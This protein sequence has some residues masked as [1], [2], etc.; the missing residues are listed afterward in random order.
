MRAASGAGRL[1]AVG[2][3][4]VAATALVALSAASGAAAAGGAAGGAVA[5]Q[6]RCG[7]F[8]NPTPGNVWLLDRDREWIIGLQGGHQVPGDWPWPRFAADQWVEVNGRYGHGCACLGVRVDGAS[9][10]IVAISGAEAR[11]LAACRAD[12][13][14]RRW[15]RFAP[16]ASPASPASP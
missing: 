14:L 12:P 13:G 3:A 2:A 16:P 4:E 1:T 15:G 5:W 6:T 11:P 9:G 8:V 7:W 10:R